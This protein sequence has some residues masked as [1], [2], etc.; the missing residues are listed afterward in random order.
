MTAC[1]TAPIPTSSDSATKVFVFIS[2]LSSSNLFSTLLLPPC[3]L[4]GSEKL[5]TVYHMIIAFN[6]CMG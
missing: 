5:K 6:R 3:T 1:S 4:A 2:H